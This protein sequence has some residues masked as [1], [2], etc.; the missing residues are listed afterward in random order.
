MAAIGFPLESSREVI[1]YFCEN[2]IQTECDEDGRV[3]FIGVC[4]SSAF[5][6]QYRGVDVFDVTARELFQMVANA[7]DSGDHEFNKLEYCFPNQVLTLWNADPQYDHRGKGARE[8]WG[9]VGLGNEVY[10]SAIK[11]LENDA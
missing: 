11:A 7:D 5:I 1:D 10:V 3:M 8:V 9:Q 4:C 6:A 2:S